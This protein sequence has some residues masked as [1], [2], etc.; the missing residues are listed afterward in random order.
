S[1]CAQFK[2]AFNPF[3]T[4]EEVEEVVSGVRDPATGG[5]IL[6]T[7]YA[8]NIVTRVK[9]GWER[10]I[11]GAKTAN[12]TLNPTPTAPFVNIGLGVLSAGLALFARFKTKRAAR[13]AGLQTTL[14]KGFEM[15]RHEATK[16]SITGVRQIVRTIETFKRIPTFNPPPQKHPTLP[17]VPSKGGAF[18]LPK[19][20]NSKKIKKVL[21]SFF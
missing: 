19:F 18:F 13:E 21:E 4:H 15:A 17:K 6:S 3:E 5:M 10:G 14:I 1:G 16:N 12:S 11:S 20:I 8:T 2:S 9:P 7:N